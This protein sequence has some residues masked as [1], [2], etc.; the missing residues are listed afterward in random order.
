MMRRR[1][2]LLALFA[3][4]WTT[5]AL[6]QGPSP[7]PASTPATR[8]TSDG[9]G[10]AGKW[11]SRNFHNDPAPLRDDPNTAPAKALAL[12]FAEAVFTF[13]LPSSTTLKGA[14]DW[15]GGGLDLQR[16]VRPGSAGGVLSVE[17]VGT[18]TEGWQ[19]DYRG[20]LAYQWPNGVIK[21]RRWSARRFAPI[22][23]APPLPTMS[24]L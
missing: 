4:L 14:I 24:P 13:E 6:A 8:V 9:S 20:E 2:I 7:P 1:A 21:S 23:M 11:T 17:I 16:T 3:S 15:P 12:I 5:S 10:L 18:G 22:R 19:Y